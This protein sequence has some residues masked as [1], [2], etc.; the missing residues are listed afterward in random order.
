AARGGDAADGIAPVLGLDAPQLA[1]RIA[2]GL[3]PGDLAPLVADALPDHR[4]GDAVLVRRVA[5]GEA[6]LDARVAVVR[7]AVAVR[8]HAHDLDVRALPAQLGLEAAADAAVG[9]GSAHRALGDSEA[10]DRLLGE[11]GGRTGLDAR[12]AGDALG[13][14]ER[15]VLAGRDLRVEAAALDSERERALRLRAGAHTARADDGQLR[16]EDEVRIAV[17]E[18]VRA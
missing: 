15:L 18:R 12:S 9:A 10:D 13:I 8:H 7:L 5:P 4:L 2:D 11:R 16:V 14:E 17:I 3:L 6:S 1:R